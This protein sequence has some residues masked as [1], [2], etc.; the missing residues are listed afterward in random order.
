[1]QAQAAEFSGCAGNSAAF[2]EKSF[3]NSLF[4]FIYFRNRLLSGRAASV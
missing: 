1:M 4:R 2:G 3:K